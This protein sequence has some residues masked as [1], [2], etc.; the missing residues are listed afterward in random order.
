MTSAA[1][2]VFIGNGSGNTIT[3]GT[4]NIFIGSGAGNTITTTSNNIMIGNAGTV[5][6]AGK[7]IIGGVNQTTN[8]QAGI[9]GVT[10]GTAAI[11]V[12]VDTL[13]QLGTV[14]SIRSKKYDIEAIDEEV[15]SRAVNAMIPRTFRMIGDTTKQ[16]NYGMIVDEVV[17]ICPDMIA[18]DSKGEQETLFYQFLPTMLL[19]ELQRHT[20]K[21]A[22]LEAIIARAG[23]V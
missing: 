9:R 16:I 23:L 14:S 2:S 4:A 15:N 10:T 12:L 3:T 20:R 5:A 19:K 22:E 7:I 21:I 6:D 8:W 11:A 17:D 1:T 13:G 18:Y